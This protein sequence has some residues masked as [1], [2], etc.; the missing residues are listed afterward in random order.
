M[1]LISLHSDAVRSLEQLRVPFDDLTPEGLWGSPYHLVAMTPEQRDVL[2][3]WS[4]DVDDV[5]PR[6]FGKHGVLLQL[7]EDSPA[8]ELKLVLEPRSD[9]APIITKAP[10]RVREAHIPITREAQVP[11]PMVEEPAHH[12]EPFAVSDDRELVGRA[13][14]QAEA[15]AE[16][17][18]LDVTAD[19]LFVSS[20]S[21]VIDPPERAADNAPRREPPRLRVS[22]GGRYR[23]AAV[24]EGKILLDGHAYDTPAHATH[25][26]APSKGDWVFWEYFD[27]D[28]GKW[29]MLDRDWQPGASA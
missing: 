5:T 29:R 6:V 22:V 28:A 17:E 12:S 26:V 13:A 25:S 7:H 20:I 11:V 3:A 14:A 4:L 27:A 9:D 16:A 23:E 2:A 19:S 8:T 21:S 10:E 1:R 18:A 15:E 24:R